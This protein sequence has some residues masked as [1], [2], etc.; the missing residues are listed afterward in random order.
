MNVQANNNNGATGGN[1]K[2]PNKLGYVT[3]QGINHFDREGLQEVPVGT[4]HR[5]N[6]RHAS[7]AMSDFMLY[8]Y[9]MMA[10]VDE[11]LKIMRQVDRDAPGLVP[12]RFNLN[13]TL[14]ER[15][16]GRYGTLVVACHKKQC[17]G[18]MDDLALQVSTTVMVASDPPRRLPSLFATLKRRSSLKCNLPLRKN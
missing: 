18:Y 10:P 17:N 1:R 5:Y 9:A 14:I 3:E 6:Q 4:I 2:Y 8:C 11:L 7:L 12:N 13:K 15:K 16:G